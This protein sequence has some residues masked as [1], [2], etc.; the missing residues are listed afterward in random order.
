MEKIKN[1]CNN[2]KYALTPI[3]ELP[4]R[5]CSLLPRES[6]WVTENIRVKNVN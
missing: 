2:C 4:C 6:K 3:L 1:G 5:I